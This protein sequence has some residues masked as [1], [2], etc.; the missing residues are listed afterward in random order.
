MRTVPRGGA[1]HTLLILLGLTVAP[2]CGSA[3]PPRTELLT[4]AASSLTDVL[5]PLARA[6]EARHPGVHIRLVFGG[7]AA[8][9]RQILEG[10][11]VD[12]FLTADPATMDQVAAAGLLQP[13]SRRD[14][15]ENRLVV[16]VPADAAGTPPQAPPD[17]ARPAIR[18]LAIG[19]EGVPVGTYARRFLRHAGLLPQ[20]TPRL[21]QFEHARAVLA[22]VAAGTVEAGLVYATDAAVESRVRV[23]FVVPAAATGCIQYPA[24]VLARAPAGEAAGRWFDFLSGPEAADRV[25]AAGFRPASLAGS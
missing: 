21:V 18:R 14:L 22:A 8:L 3:P 11:P 2:G 6:F 9:A 4:A 5:P 25:R 20:V 19:A 17:L 16:I 23:A 7:S 10:A 12:C 1:W 13:H 15:L 24:A